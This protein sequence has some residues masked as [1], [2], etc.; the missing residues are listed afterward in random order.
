MMVGHTHDDIDQMF[1]RFSIG[2]RKA[3][4]V[5]YSVPQLGKILVQSSKP[6]PDVVFLY[7]VHDWKSCLD[8]FSTSQLE[9]TPLH[10]HLR[11]LQYHLFLNDE[12]RS[13]LKWKRFSVQEEWFPILETTTTS[14][15]VFKG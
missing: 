5:V 6:T 9:N 11:P 15:V 1:S 7:E 4:G 8:T 3:N 14:A 13:V 2:I 12:G 10:G